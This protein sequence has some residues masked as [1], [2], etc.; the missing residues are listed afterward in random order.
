MLRNISSS[1]D[2]RS[3]YTAYTRARRTEYCGRFTSSGSLA[4]FAAMRRASSRVSRLAA[5][6]AA[7]VHKKRGCL[8]ALVGSNCFIHC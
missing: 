3:N 2:S 1:T 7:F 6:R 4:M 8:P 5:Y